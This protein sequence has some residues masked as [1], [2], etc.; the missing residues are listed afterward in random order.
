MTIWWIGQSVKAL[1]MAL[2]MNQRDF[3]QL[4]DAGQ[5]TVS[6]WERGESAV[7][8]AAQVALDSL[9]AT[10]EPVAR[11]RFEV[12]A[13]ETDVNRRQFLMTST[14]L[15]ATAG[16]AKPTVTP[17]AIDHL[18][19]TVHAGMLLDDSLGSDAAKP[20]VDAMAR[21]CLTLLPDCPELLKPQLSRLTAEAV[22]SSAWAA[23]D[24]RDVRLADALFGQAFE[25]AENAG[26]TDVQAG[27]LVHR[28]DL[29]VWTRRYADAADYADAALA[30]KIRDRRM[31]DYRALRSAQAFAHANRRQDARRQ[32]E[33]VSGEHITETTPDQSYAYW[34]A[35]WVTSDV[36]GSVLEATGDRHGAAESVEESLQFIPELASRHRAL[37]LLRLARIAA[38]LDLD[39]SVD[40]AKQAL[41]LSRKNTSPRLRQKYAET[42]Q[43]L[44]PW[45]GTRAIRELDAFADSR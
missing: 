23:W 41:A 43:L 2:R 42:R 7:N 8:V 37:T 34:M 3:G 12:L 6:G 18:R 25:H 11:A 38:P 21:T 17:A 29:A 39:R 4:I 22:A 9:L 36:T 28:T 16:S 19:T 26:D 31:A 10:L 32:L 20:L 5:R 45:D 13:E 35:G 30:I 40:A 24:Q 27:I 44:E 14:A 1:R 15:A 33:A